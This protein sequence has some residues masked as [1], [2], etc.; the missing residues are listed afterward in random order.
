MRLAMLALAG[1]V[2]ATSSPV[3]AQQPADRGDVRCLLVL[4]AVGRDPKQQESAVRGIFYYLGKL[5]ARGGLTRVEPMVLAEARTLQPQQAQA[6]LNR[7]GQELNGRASG[8]EAMNK[9]LQAAAQAAAP[10]KK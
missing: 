3:A 6:E 5:E 9:R 1:A 7:C 4:Q 10:K 8:L 2:A